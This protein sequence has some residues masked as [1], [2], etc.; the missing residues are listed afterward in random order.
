MTS[1]THRLLIVDVDNINPTTEQLLSAERT[2][3][4]VQFAYTMTRYAAGD[5]GMS[6][7]GLIDIQIIRLVLSAPGSFLVNGLY[8][9]K[10][11]ESPFKVE[12][13][14]NVKPA[15]GHLDLTRPASWLFGG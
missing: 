4:S 6:V 9:P 8:H 5:F 2:K 10:K 12:G 13:W 1:R 7:R 14:F 3:T 11:G 15:H